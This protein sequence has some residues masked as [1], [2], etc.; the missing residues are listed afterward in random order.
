M[1]NVIRMSRIEH[2]FWFISVYLVAFACECVQYFE[3][4]LK[5]ST[6]KPRLRRNVLFF[7]DL[8]KFRKDLRCLLA[9]LAHVCSFISSTSHQTLRSFNLFNNF[10]ICRFETKIS[11]TGC[12]FSFFFYTFLSAC[13]SVVL[14]ATAEKKSK[15]KATERWCLCGR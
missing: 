10:F 13:G 5:N 3:V 15:T 7:A 11:T 6:W 1:Q 2:W 4:Y 8:I 12:I 14:H 9:S